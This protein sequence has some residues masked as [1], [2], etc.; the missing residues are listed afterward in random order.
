MKPSKNVSEVPIFIQ[1]SLKYARQKISGR[2][3][4]ASHQEF[5]SGIL[6]AS[7]CT[8]QFTFYGYILDSTDI[9]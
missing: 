9:T 5:L 2:S 1:K 3:D 4:L 6:N 7:R 8:V